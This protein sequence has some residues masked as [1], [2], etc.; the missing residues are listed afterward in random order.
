MIYISNVIN[1]PYL[2]KSILFSLT[3]LINKNSCSC[4]FLNTK[5]D[6]YNYNRCR[7]SFRVKFAVD[8]KFM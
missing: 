4:K 1:V 8:L 2:N 7:L 6:L 3:G 5:I